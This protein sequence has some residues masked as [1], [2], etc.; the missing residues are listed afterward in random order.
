MEEGSG[1]QDDFRPSHRSKGKQSLHH[2]GMLRK[3]FWPLVYLLSLLEHI[4][5]C[6]RLIYNSGNLLQREQVFLWD[7]APWEAECTSGGGGAC[8][9]TVRWRQGQEEEEAGGRERTRQR[10]KREHDPLPPSAGSPLLSAYLDYVTLC[11]G[12][13][14]KQ[15]LR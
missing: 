3:T 11:S 4:F 14:R 9:S 6:W 8:H 7:E 12:F 13:L 5:L 10:S 1:G 2:S 15:S